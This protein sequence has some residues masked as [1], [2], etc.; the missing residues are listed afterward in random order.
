MIRKGDFMAHQHRASSV[1]RAGPPWV[2]PLM[3]LSF[4]WQRVEGFHV[5]RDQGTSQKHLFERPDRAGLVSMALHGPHGAHM[6]PTSK[7]NILVSVHIHRAVF[8]FWKDSA[9]SPVPQ[10]WLSVPCSVK[11]KN[12]KDPTD[13]VPLKLHV[14]FTPSF[15]RQ[16]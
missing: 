7:R 1:W 11:S 14:D 6:W 8:Y 15:K 3:A 9:G 4:W 12:Y 16:P 2:G 13:A 10:Y 5:L